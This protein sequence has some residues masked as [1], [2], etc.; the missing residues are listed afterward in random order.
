VD[1]QACSIGSTDEP[2]TCEFATPRGGRYQITAEVT[3]SQG[4]IN[5]SRL[6][7]WVSGGERPPSRDVEQEQVTLIPDQEIYQPGDVAEILVEAPFSSGEGLLTISRS[8]IISTQQFR[9]DGTSYTLRIPIEDKYIPNLHIQV[10]VVGSA[11]RT[12]DQGEKL[13]GA[14]P[15]P[16]FATGQLTSPFR[17]SPELWR[18]KLCR[19]RMPWS[20]ALR[21]GWISVCA[22]LLVNPWQARSWRLWWWMKPSWV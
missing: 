15:R 12:D 10:D 4:R 20:R 2:L 6:T 16:A 3:D 17:L 21:P 19:G 22:M 7:R 8:G 1:P 13:E 9:L 5:Q 11:P 18:W 14:P